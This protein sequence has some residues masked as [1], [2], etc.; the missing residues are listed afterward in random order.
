MTDFDYAN[1]SSGHP[2][3]W[4][5]V[6]GAPFLPAQRAGL[7]PRGVRLYDTVALTLMFDGDPLVLAHVAGPGENLIT[8]LAV[9]AEGFDAISEDLHVFSA[10]NMIFAQAAEGHAVELLHLTSTSYVEAPAATAVLAHP[11]P[12]E[13]GDTKL[14]ITLIRD[15]AEVLFEVGRQG[16]TM[17]DMAALASRLNRTVF[18]S[19]T[20]TAD[21]FLVS[22][23]AG[24]VL[25]A[26]AL[27]YA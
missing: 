23:H 24:H 25:I 19:A 7:D 9:I 20:P 12:A 21:A 27:E 3:G 5:H 2:T 11:T 6:Y 16:S 26:G 4:S 18:F 17:E 15:G 1:V 22:T 8:A 14:Q 10:G 13:P